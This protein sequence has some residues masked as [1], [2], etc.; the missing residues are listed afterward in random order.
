MYVNITELGKIFNGL[1]FKWW[2]RVPRHI[3]VYDSEKKYI[4]YIDVREHN[5]VEVNNAETAQR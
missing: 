3:S 4:G 1:N 5:F 2:A